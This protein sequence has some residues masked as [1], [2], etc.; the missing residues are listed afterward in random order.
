MKRTLWNL[1]GVVV[2]AVGLAGCS[3]DM[4]QAMLKDPQLQAKVMDM[5]GGNADMAG[6]MMDKLVGSEETRAMVLD[7]VMGNGELVQQVMARVTEDPAMVE[8][9]L[10]AVITNPAM[11][12]KLSNWAGLM[13]GASKA[14]AAKAP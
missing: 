9:M 5:I 8:H 1:V 12:D 13:Q 10:G 6:A 2:I 7:K 11:K 14:M 3:G 4:T